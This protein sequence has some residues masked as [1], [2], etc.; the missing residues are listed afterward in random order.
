MAVENIVKHK[1]KKPRYCSEKCKM[2]MY[3]PLC[4]GGGGSA[5]NGG[6][7]GIFGFLGR[8]YPEVDIFGGGMKGTC[9]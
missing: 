5:C 8:E 2:Y 3:A 4:G 6:G 1:A 9:K 7:S